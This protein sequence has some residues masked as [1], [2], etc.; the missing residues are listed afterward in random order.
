LIFVFASV[1]DEEIGLLNG[2]HVSLSVDMIFQ[3]VG[4]V[5]GREILSGRPCP[6]PAAVTVIEERAQH[7]TQAGYA[8]LLGAGGPVPDRTMA[9][10]F[11]RMMAAQRCWSI[12]E[13]AN[14]LM[15]VSSK[16]QERSPAA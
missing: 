1:A 14:K 3:I 6:L 8:F 13:T 16:G 12:E 15:E 4:W 10:F 7:K 11:W 2:R 5:V 9:D